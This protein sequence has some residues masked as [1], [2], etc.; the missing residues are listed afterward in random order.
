MGISAPESILYGASE[1]Q[2]ATNYLMMHIFNDWDKKSQLTWLASL[3]GTGEATIVDFDVLGYSFYPLYGK[4]VGQFERHCIDVSEAASC[5][6]H[7]L[8]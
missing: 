2:G 1:R 8:A 7:R 5:R 4:S 3:L 6:G